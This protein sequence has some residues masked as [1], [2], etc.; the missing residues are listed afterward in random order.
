M[1]YTFEIVLN[2]IVYYA[3]CEY[4]FGPMQNTSGDPDDNRQN[5]GVTDIDV[6]EVY[7]WDNNICNDKIKEIQKHINNNFGRY[8]GKIE[9]QFI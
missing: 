6:I 7:D 5:E 2:S 9:S 8:S 1:E 3:N 4:E